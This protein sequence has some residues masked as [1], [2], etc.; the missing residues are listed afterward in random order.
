MC[1]T[2][3]SFLWIYP[4]GFTHFF[5]SYLQVHTSQMRKLNCLRKSLQNLSILLRWGCSTYWRMTW[6]GKQPF[7][8]SITLSYYSRFPINCALSHNFLQEVMVLCPATHLLPSGDDTTLYWP[9]PYHVLI[10]PTAEYTNMFKPFLQWFSLQKSKSHVRR[11]PWMSNDK[12]V[13]NSTKGLWTQ[14][15]IQGQNFSLWHWANGC[16]FSGL[17]QWRFKCTGPGICCIY[18]LIFDI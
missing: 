8:Y 5:G 13:S 11:R 14:F 7:L 4:P 18:F 9:L 10:Y 16:L 12:D 1:H 15:S 17:P 3:L 2:D 6:V